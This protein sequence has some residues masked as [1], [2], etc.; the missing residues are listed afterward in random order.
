MYKKLISSILVVALLHLVGCSTPKM[1]TKEEFQQASEY[2]DLE[3]QFPHDT[4]YQFDEGDYVVQSD[5][6][7][8]KGKVKSK[9]GRRVVYNDYEGSISIEE[10]EEIRIDKFDVLTTIVLVVAIAGIGA[11]LGAAAKSGAEDLREQIRESFESLR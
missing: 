4:V 7:Y 5:S 3:V 6:V 1:I 9:V 10:A 8:G 11:A 2:P